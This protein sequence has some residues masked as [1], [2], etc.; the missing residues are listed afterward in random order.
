[1]HEISLIYTWGLWSLKKLN[2][3]SK[4]TKLLRRRARIWTI[5]FLDPEFMHIHCITPCSMFKLGK[6]ENSAGNGSQAINNQVYP[7]GPGGYG[8]ANIGII[9]A[10]NDPH[11]FQWSRVTQTESIYSQWVLFLRHLYCFQHHLFQSGFHPPNRNKNNCIKR[12]MWGLFEITYIK[13]LAWNV[14]AE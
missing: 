10:M 7:A 8:K 9:W 2:D 13:V 5:G 3:L 14:Y 1:M 4:A 6:H 12:F 11:F